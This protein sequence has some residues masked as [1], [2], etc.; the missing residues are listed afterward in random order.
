MGGRERERER[1]GQSTQDSLPD[2]AEGTG[3]RETHTAERTNETC[4]PEIDQ[5]DIPG[6]TETR[7]DRHKQRERER[8]R[9]TER[10]TERERRERER[11]R[12]RCT[13]RASSAPLR[14]PARQAEERT[15]AFLSGTAVIGQ[16]QGRKE[17]QLDRHSATRREA[18]ERGRGCCVVATA[19]TATTRVHPAPCRRVTGRGY[20]YEYE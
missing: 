2:V 8:E 7:R 10:Q 6:E 3:E 20:M 11:E 14:A 18:R 5:R 19:P 1:E 13:W 17:G 9:D 4:E 12:P 16:L 15:S